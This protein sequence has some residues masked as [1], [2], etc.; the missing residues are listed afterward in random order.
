MDDVAA[1]EHFFV[2][3]FDFRRKGAI[4]DQMIEMHVS[5]LFTSHH[6]YRAP[7]HSIVYMLLFIQGSESGISLFLI[8]ASAFPNGVLGGEEKNCHM[9]HHSF[10]LQGPW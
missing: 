9:C 3:M 6:R 5:L 8:G 7:I 1:A 2:D 10:L 4:S